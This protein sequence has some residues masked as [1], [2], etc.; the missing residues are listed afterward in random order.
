MHELIDI[1]EKQ[2]NKNHLKFQNFLKNENNK[3]DKFSIK[4]LTNI[5]ILNDEF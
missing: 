1:L 2:K 3:I 5:N 4:K